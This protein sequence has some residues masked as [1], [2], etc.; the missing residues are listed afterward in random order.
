M[1]GFPQQTLQLFIKI[2]ITLKKR[3]SLS[4]KNVIC[5]MKNLAF[6]YKR[7]SFSSTVPAAVTNIDNIEET[8]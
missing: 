3:S 6:L 8:L 4:F 5:R 7:S 2:L 1:F